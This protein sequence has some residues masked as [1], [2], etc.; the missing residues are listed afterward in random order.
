M[1]T[2]GPAQLRVRWLDDDEPYDPG[3]MDHCEDHREPTRGCETCDA[4]SR[5]VWHEVET[6]GVYGC[7][8]ETRAPA[9]GC[10]GRTDWEHAASL[11]GIVGD[12]DYHRE[13][14]AELMSEVQVPREDGR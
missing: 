3:D 2:Y 1:A 7:V 9:C 4:Y 10:C 6:W 14:E 8:L 13:V 11:W 12:A 5:E